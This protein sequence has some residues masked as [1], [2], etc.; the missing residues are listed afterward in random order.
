[1]LVIPVGVQTCIFTVAI[2]EN[3]FLNLI[4][5]NSLAYLSKNFFRLLHVLAIIHVLFSCK[6]VS[7]M[8]AW[9]IFYMFLFW[10]FAFAPELI[11]CRLPIF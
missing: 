3:P 10:R 2:E 4:Q 11:I 6:S 9:P 5:N 7:T 8:N 1:M